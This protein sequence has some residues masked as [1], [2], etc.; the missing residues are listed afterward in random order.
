MRQYEMFELNLKGHK[1][2]GSEALADVEAEFT[3]GVNVQKVKGFYAGDGMYKV[4]FLPRECGTYRWKIRGAVNGQGSEECIKGEGHGMVQA[5]G[6]HFQYEDGTR[7]IPFGTTVYAI[8]HQEPSLIE[9]TFESLKEAPFNKLRHCVF[10]KSYEYNQNDPALYP[11]CRDENGNWDP[12]HPDYRFWDAFE[13]II[14]RLG[15]MGIESDLILFH[16]YDRWG[17]STMTSEQNETYLRYAVRRLAA[18]PYIW[19]S[20]ANEYD[21]CFDKTPD[22]WARFEEIIKEEDPYGHLLSNHYCMKMYDYSRK[23]ITHCSM[24]NML[25]FKAEKWMEQYKKPVVFDECCYEGDLYFSWG[26]ISAAEMVSRFWSAYCTGAFATHGETFLSED[27]V[28]WWAKGGKL[29]GESPKKI[30]FLREVIESLPSA[31]EPWREPEYLL[32]G[33]DFKEKMQGGENPFEKLHASL[34]E[35]EDDAGALKD[36][37]LSGHCGQD[38]FIKYYGVHCPSRAFFILPEDRTYKIEVIDIWKETRETV[39]EGAKGITWFDM[40]GKEKMAVL[41][42]VEK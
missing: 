10:P 1:P 14:F 9:E 30:A 15:K 6:C 16:P 28:L 21:L 11:F 34:S 36:K 13:E 40:P 39:K 35:T 24:Q 2:E 18:I 20:M 27:D 33:P 22:D 42:T 41:A 32:Y 7:Y 17:F 12:S 38:A 31:V 4:R 29:K 37:V 25:F 26:N 19:W 23:N 8:A 3:C 5:E